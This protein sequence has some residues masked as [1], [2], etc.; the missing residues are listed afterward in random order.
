MAAPEYCVKPASHTSTSTTS[1]PRTTPNNPPIT[2]S[3]QSEP[4]AFSN[5]AIN[6]AS[7]PHT[8][9]AAMNTSA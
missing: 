5:L 8:I 9:N 3:D 7:M 6:L 2:L 1:P 4:T